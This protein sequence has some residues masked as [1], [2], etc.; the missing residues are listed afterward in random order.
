MTTLK[1]RAPY[2]D[3]EISRLYPSSLELQQVQIIL[4]VSQQYLGSRVP[5]QEM[6]ADC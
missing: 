6:A 5:G 4:R 2:T 1:P 3:E